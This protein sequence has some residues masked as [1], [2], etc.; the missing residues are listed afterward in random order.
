MGRPWEGL[1]EEV[2]RRRWQR[3]VA[4]ATLVSGS[5]SGA[6]DLVQEALVG[7]FAGR[8]RFTTPEQAEAYLR[9]TIASRAVDASRRRAREHR[10]AARLAGC[11]PMTTTDVD[12]LP[13]ADVV[14]A[15]GALGPRERA[16]VVLRQMEDMSVAETAA[17][18]GLSEG[19]VK[20]YTSD[21][22]RR[23]ADLLD[24]DPGRLGDETT[25]VETTSTEVRRA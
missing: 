16:C 22:V 10:L 21:A 4:Y 20:R 2:A 9:R 13:G 18:L 5:Y 19:A 12:T 15:L 11:T 8:A 3:L 14:R 1:L 7:V 24:A 17:V 25:T 23:L 6:E